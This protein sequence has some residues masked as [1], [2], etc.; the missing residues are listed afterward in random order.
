M[1]WMTKTL[2]MALPARAVNCILLKTPD[3]LH[4]TILQGIGMTALWILVFGFAC[5]WVMRK[6]EFI[7]KKNL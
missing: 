4:P 1:Q 2:T 5:L 3:P 6:S 7:A